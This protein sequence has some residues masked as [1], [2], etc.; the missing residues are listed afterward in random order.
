MRTPACE[1]LEDYLD[2]D[3]AGV[4]LSQFVDH[5]PECS[6]C[7]LAIAEHERLE[8]LVIDAARLEPI[9]AG[10]VSRI[11]ARMRL[12]R[13]LR[14]AGIAAAVA[15]SFA[16]IW[17]IGHYVPL[18]KQPEPAVAIGPTEP[19]PSETLPAAD[20]VRVTFPAGSNVLIVREKSEIP[21][22]T[23]VQIY[24]GLYRGPSL[25]KAPSSSTPE[26]SHE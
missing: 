26:R 8:K 5:L 14:W 12:T 11:E 6:S 25:A 17:L 7:R 22:V 24:S 1:Y 9:P 23:F 16:V 13:R 19:S 10:L 3:L 2:H 20:H 15:A 18:A 4:E 21:N